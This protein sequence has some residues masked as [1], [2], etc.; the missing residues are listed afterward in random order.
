MSRISP[1]P[2]NTRGEAATARPAASTALRVE[3]L[4]AGSERE[5]LAFLSAR[6]VH[7]VIM[8][9]FI[10]DNGLESRYNRGEF[11]ACRSARG[12]LEG[13][14]LLG[15]ATLAETRTRA[16]LA[17]LAGHART[18]PRPHLIV[19]ER[20][21]V[22]RFWRGYAQADEPA[23]R[24]YT[25]LLLEQRWPVEVREPVPGLRRATQGDSALVLKVHAALALAQSGVDPLK[26]DPEGFLARTARRIEQGRIWV[27]IEAG[28]LVFKADLVSETPEVSYLEGVY[29]RP[30]DRGKGYGLRCLSQLSRNLL[31]RTEAVCL[32]VNSENP[33]AA[34][35]YRRAGYRHVGDYETIFPR[36]DARD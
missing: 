34:A 11:Y 25:E 15:H 19:G 18:L 6:P 7:T 12:R 28:R 27:W 10:R 29:V 21:S 4:G 2:S 33:A 30:E 23:P 14:A 22:S 26:A 31:A 1:R 5:T 24:S 3:R 8:S 36:L 9:S 35:L 17:A 16:A 20:E 13:V 32:L